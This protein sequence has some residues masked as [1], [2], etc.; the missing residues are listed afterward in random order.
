MPNLLTQLKRHEG[1]RL[2]P[3]RDTVGKL[4]IGFGRNLEDRGI[5]EDEAKI[6]LV[7]DVCRLRGELSEIDWWRALN[8]VRRDVIVNMAYN[9]GVSGVLG[10]E[11]MIAAL[12]AKDYELAAIEMLDSKWADQV[13]RRAVEL[14][15]QMHTGRR[16]PA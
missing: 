4:T 8:D 12:R 14:S 1:L 13:G 7:N 16:R 11:R 6:L 3:Y 10:F 9:L 2:R 5:T 15:D